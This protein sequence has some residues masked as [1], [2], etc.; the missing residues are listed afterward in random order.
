MKNILITYGT[1]TGNTEIVSEGMQA[2]LTEHAERLDV[3]PTLLNNY[4]VEPIQ[5][6]D[7]DL[8]VIG[9]STW[10]DNE[11]NPVTEDF[12]MRLE[13]EGIDLSGVK[14]AVFGLGETI[15]PI[16]CGAA[17]MISEKMQQLGAELVGELH[18]IDGYPDET[19]LAAANNWLENLLASN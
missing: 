2:F 19:I 9:A 12:L 18:K 5:L 17:D 10:G 15:Y 8:V 3:N 13:N 16:F 6:R 14:V 1:L 11:P 7:Y 4:E